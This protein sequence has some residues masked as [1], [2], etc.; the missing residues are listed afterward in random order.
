V[1][2]RI[3]RHIQIRG[4]VQGVGFRPFVHQLASALELSG[5]IRNSG[6]GVVC[7]VEGYAIDEFKCRVQAELPANAIISR[8]ESQTVPVQNDVGFQ[9]RESDI[10][11]AVDTLIQPDLATCPECVKEIFDPGNRRY[12]YPFTNCTHC[13]PRF[14]IIEAIPYDRANTTMK[15][16]K[17][18]D[19]CEAEYGD[20]TD[21][22]FHAQPNACPKC[23]PQVWLTGAEGERMAER[24]DALERAVTEL[25]QG[26]IVAIK[27]IGGFHLFADARDEAAIHRLRERKRR[28]NK[29]FALMY[30]SADR[31]ANDCEVLIGERELLESVAAPIVLLR[32]GE[33]CSIADVVAPGN[34]WLGVMIPYSPL[35]HLLLSELDGPVVATSGNLAEEPICFT[36][37]D[38]L[39]DLK[40]IADVFLL[41]DRP[42]RRPV[43]DSIIRIVA[44]REMILRRSRGYAPLPVPVPGS[45]R[46]VL[47]VGADLKNTVALLRGGNV[48][49]S[50]HQGDLGTERSLEAHTRAKNDLPAIYLT[51]AASVASDLHPAYFSTKQAG[52]SAVGV[53][54]HH[55]HIVACMAE[56]GIRGECLGVAFDGTGYGTDGTIWGGEFLLLDDQGFKRCNWLRT[57]PL[58]GGEKAIRDPRFTAVGMLFEAGLL[59]D[60]RAKKFLRALSAEELTVVRSLLDKAVNCPRTSSMG[61]LFDGVAALAGLCFCNSFEGEAAMGMEFACAGVEAEPYPVTVGQP[62]DWRPMLTALLANLHDGV[63]VSVVAGRFHGWLVEVIVQQAIASGQKR[64]VMSGGCFQNQ[65]LL[66]ASIERLRG[67]GFEVYWPQRVPPNDRGIAL[68][69]AVVA[70]GTNGQSTRM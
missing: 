35:H 2:E 62:I 32:R 1:P 10:G 52:V 55:A 33:Q 31:I 17:M 5:W 60:T 68:G 57:F 20:P 59:N 58:P 11:A 56:H 51:G 36:N 16:F 41:H 6:S 29:P 22:R 18:C 46:T 15:G 24:Q 63:D 69:Q 8:I 23:G 26:K 34:P 67:A 38:A 43:D 19:A 9:I 61:R 13:G 37:G 42:I 7:E 47:A 28:G 30:A 44:G 27:G 50:Q 4:A 45:D 70:A 3:R 65:V 66:E 25:R 12:G 49:L 48:F 21:R 40:G 39:A 53:Q 64:V 14:S 54:H